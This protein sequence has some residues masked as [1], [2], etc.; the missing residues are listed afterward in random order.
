MK[1]WVVKVQCSGKTPMWCGDFP[2]QGRTEAK[3]AARHFVSQHLPLETRILA[4]AMGRIDIHFEG[5]EIDESDQ[6]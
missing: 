4:I 3:R 1:S 5:P 2:A 6:E